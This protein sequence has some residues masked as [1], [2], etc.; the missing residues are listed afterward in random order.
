MFVPVFIL[1]FEVSKMKTDMLD[2]NDLEAVRAHGLTEQEVENQLEQFRRGFPYS[3]IVRPAVA[4]DGVVC[5]G[6][7]EIRRLGV[8]YDEAAR[9]ER[10]VKFVPASGA[11]TRMFKGLYE[12]LATGSEDKATAEVLASVDRFAFGGRLRG[13][14]PEGA[15]AAETVEAIVGDRGLGYGSLPKALILFHVYPEGART[16][17]EEHLVEGAA[18][19]RSGGDVHIH[20]TVSPEHRA[21]FDRLLEQV[22]S[23]YSER[24]G[25]RYHIGMSEQKPSTDTVAV[26]PDNTLF[27]NA[28]GSLLFRPAGHGA[29]I[30][31]LNDLD[32]DIVFVKNIDNVTTDTRR[33]DTVACK[34]ALGGLL[35]ELRE[36]I[37]DLLR[38]A[39]N[40]A[41]DDRWMEEATRFVA[42][43]LCVAMP[44]PVAQTGKADRIGWLCRILDRPLRVC[45]MVRNEGEP[46]GGPFFVRMAD[47]T[48]SLQIV[49]SSQ[50]A[51]QDRPIMAQ[52]TYFNPVDLVCSL[53]DGKGR[54][55][56][57]TR[58]I[59]P[60]TGFISEKSKDGRP[61]RAL[62]RPG[63]WN[64]AMAHWNTVFVEVPGTTFS[65]VK[66][67]NDLLRPAHQPETR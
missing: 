67:V 40:G 30:E 44:E 1:T 2:R 36:R 58:Y 15:S 10:I 28:E 26:N 5:L 43:R 64:G 27:R 16:A 63:L 25:V 3:E 38:R 23:A 66:V 12:F 41:A 50:I 55:Y 22:L 45:G 34:K 31:N 51:P 42:E 33:A 13:M 61:L 21:G 32:A 6:E 62:E 60:D 47:G 29:L 24:F 9:T 65:P 14:L 11:A 8:R 35:V 46:G 18:Y 48:A 53:R 37:R 19:A 59:D 7:D 56:D 4:G 54:K 17:L 52:A 49:E 20:F 39:E 57:L